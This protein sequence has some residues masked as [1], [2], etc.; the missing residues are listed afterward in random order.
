METAKEISFFKAFIII[1]IA[2]GHEILQVFFLNNSVD[3]DQM[4]WLIWI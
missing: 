2:C 3:P 4:C 1:V